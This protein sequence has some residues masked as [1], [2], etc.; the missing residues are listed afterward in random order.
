MKV[1]TLN[2]EREEAKERFIDEIKEATQFIV[3]L[4]KFYPETNEVGYRSFRY[5][6]S[7]EESIYA[8]ELFKSDHFASLIEEIE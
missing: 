4:K 1:V 7:F 8:T 6:M 5:R 3:I 2:P